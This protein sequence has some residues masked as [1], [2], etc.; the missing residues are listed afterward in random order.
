MRSLKRGRGRRRRGDVAPVHDP[1]FL[2]HA[3]REA[4]EV[5]LAFGVHPGHLGGLAADERAA[6]ELAAARD[7]RTTSVAT[8]TSSLPQAK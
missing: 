8:G 4:R 6:R 1:A 2:D 5:V 3:H 7:P